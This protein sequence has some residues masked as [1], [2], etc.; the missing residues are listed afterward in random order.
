MQE[1][2]RKV[3]VQPGYTRENFAAY[4][5]Q[6]LISL[7]G[8]KSWQ[9][10]TEEDFPDGGITVTLPYP[11]KTGR[12]THD[13][14]VT[15]MFTLT[16]ARLGTTAGETEQPPVEKTA[17]GLKVTFHGLSPVGIAWKTLEQGGQEQPPVT[18]TGSGKSVSPKEKPEDEYSFWRQVKQQIEKAGKG[19]TVR[20]NA[21]GY[22]RLPLSVMKALRERP[23]VALAI[24]WNGG[25]P[26]TIPAGKALWEERRSYYPLSYL[27]AYDFGG[28]AA[29]DGAAY[30]DKENPGTGAPER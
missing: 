9:P 23:D 30:P 28:P 11:E 19:E 24:R 20:I 12:D 2:A 3:S 10:A 16:S 17:D 14:S 29:G 26:I 27:A 6:L 4:D 25:K 15:H 1:L 22:E 5:V 18:P 7:D 21:R 13:F 8:G